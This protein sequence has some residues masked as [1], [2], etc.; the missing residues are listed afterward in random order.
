MSRQI[1]VNCNQKFANKFRKCIVYPEFF[2]YWCQ[3]FTIML[4]SRSTFLPYLRAQNLVHFGEKIY[5]FIVKFCLF[6]RRIFLCS[7]KE[8]KGTPFEQMFLFIPVSKLVL[9]YSY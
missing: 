5:K 6:K 4:A 8:N 2:I 9:A 1:K 3:K 7:T